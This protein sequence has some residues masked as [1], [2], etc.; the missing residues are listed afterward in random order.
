MGAKAII[1]KLQETNRGISGVRTAPDEMPGAL[2]SE[3]L[4]CALSYPWEAGHSVP[5]YSGR[6]TQRRYLV[7]LYVREVGQGRGVDEGFQEC[8]PFLDRFADKYHDPAVIAPSD[9][10][11]VEAT[12][13]EDFGIRADLTLHGATGGQAYWGVVFVVG[14]KEK[15]SV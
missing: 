1:A 3:M 12:F 15:R 4:P 10:A 13:E 11:W 7:R 9:E 14:V 5:F 6:K 2:T 8:L